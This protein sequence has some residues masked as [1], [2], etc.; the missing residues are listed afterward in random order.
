M[1]TMTVFVGRDE[2]RQVDIYSKCYISCSNLNIGHKV[3]T[4]PVDSGHNNNSVGR[5]ERSQVDK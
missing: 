5:D 1:G 2:R 4:V 3:Y